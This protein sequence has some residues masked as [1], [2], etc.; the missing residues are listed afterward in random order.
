M[1]LFLPIPSISPFSTLELGTRKREK[2]WVGRMVGETGPRTG[3]RRFKAPFHLS[4]L[5][6]GI[7]WSTLLLLLLSQ[8]PPP[9]PYPTHPLTL[10]EIWHGNEEEQKERGKVECDGMEREY[11]LN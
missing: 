5:F 6:L 4:P 3:R 1:G 10:L 7:I 8:S 2:G 9:P 11:A